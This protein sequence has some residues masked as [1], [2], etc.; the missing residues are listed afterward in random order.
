MKFS[1]RQ[2]EALENKRIET[3]WKNNAPLLQEAF[4]RYGTPIPAEISEMVKIK[5]IQLDKVIPI[6]FEEFTKRWPEN[7]GT[8]DSPAMKIAEACTKSHF[9][10]LYLYAPELQEKVLEAS[11]KRR[12]T[13]NCN[14]LCEQLKKVC[15]VDASDEFKQ[16]IMDVLPVEL[17]K[18]VYF[19]GS[20]DRVKCL[21]VQ[22]NAR[23]YGDSDGVI[24]TRDGEEILTIFV[25]GLDYI[26]SFAKHLVK[27]L[28]ITEDVATK[29]SSA[30]PHDEYYTVRGFVETDIEKHA[31]QMARLLHVQEGDTVT[32]LY[33]GD[34]EVVTGVLSKKLALDLDD[35]LP[36]AILVGSRI[37][38]YLPANK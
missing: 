11:E 33:Q 3:A 4:Q 19:D 2:N 18:K 27:K 36:S 34:V 26:Q 28:G 25:E 13:A 22:A 29:I 24:Y 14:R 30:L 21:S 7:K 31:T 32:D 9:P 15:N 20:A 17:P 10:V 37:N 6:S 35:E 16:F 23:S 1:E 12:R 38:I 8:A 5:G